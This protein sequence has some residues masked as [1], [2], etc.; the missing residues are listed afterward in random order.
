MGPGFRREAAA[1]DVHPHEI[2]VEVLAPV[3][4]RDTEDE[5][6]D[7]LHETMGPI[8]RTLGEAVPAVR[9][10]SVRWR[11]GFMRACDLA[12]CALHLLPLVHRIPLLGLA[13]ARDAAMIGSRLAT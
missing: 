9:L 10:R 2:V 7:P 3:Q 11:R 5:V 1:N 12:R 8:G 6:A 4:V 13:L